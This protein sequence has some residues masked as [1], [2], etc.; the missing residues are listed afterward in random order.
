M[1]AIDGLSPRTPPATVSGDRGPLSVVQLTASTSRQAGGL[2]P[3]VQRISQVLAD[4]G[5]DV[6]VMGLE[7]PFTAQDRRSWSPLLPRTFSAFPPQAFGYSPGLSQALRSADANLVHIHGLWMYPSWANVATAKPSRPYVVSPHGMLDPWA[8]ANSRLKKRI[9][10]TLFENRHLRGAACLHALAPSERLAMRSYGLKNPIAILPNGVDP[11]PPA[12]GRDP[13]WKGHIESG[14]RILLFLGRVHPKKGLMPLLKALGGLW[15]GEST[16]ADDWALVVAGWS[17]NDHQRDLEE[18]VHQ[19]RLGERVRFVGPLH[20]Q[21]KTDA[22]HAADAFVLPS[23]SEGLPMT[24][25]E[26]WSHGLPV[27]MTAACNIERGFLVDAAM[28]LDYG[29]HQEL[30]GL[31]EFL[32]TP[33]AALRE[34]GLR[35][36]ELVAREFDWPTIGSGFLAL[37]RWIRGEAPM[38]DFVEPRI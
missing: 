23:R 24:V 30:S 19:E 15:N 37:Y 34:M 17:Q 27:A 28:R 18:L 26:A 35:G 29:E 31:R 22:L 4:R 9:V 32:E 2:L 33:A 8:L 25:L 1:S 21:D 36:R 7:D 3:T 6:S 5:A 16:A 10:A 20:G 13:V 12:S 11:A 38:P 14:K